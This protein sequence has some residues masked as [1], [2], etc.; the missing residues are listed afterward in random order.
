MWYKNVGTTFF[1]FVTKQAFDRQTDGQTDRNSL[2]VG[3]TV[4]CITYDRTVKRSDWQR[5]VINW[6]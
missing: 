5:L 3:Y 2:A 4:R 6:L 1:R